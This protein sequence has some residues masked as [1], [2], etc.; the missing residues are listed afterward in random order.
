ML[1]IAGMT[2]EGLSPSAT[3][4]GALMMNTSVIHVQCDVAGSAWVMPVGGIAPYI[5]Q[6]NTG[7]TT[8]RITDLTA[9]I[10][11]VTV[12]DAIGASINTTLIVE[13]QYLSVYDS[14]G[15][16]VDCLYSR[17]THRRYRL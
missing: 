2:Y 15:N 12:T 3:A 8:D 17:Y 13:G 5:Y 4:S 10:Y 9:G 6:W 1:T 16:P 11:E 7:E 14:D